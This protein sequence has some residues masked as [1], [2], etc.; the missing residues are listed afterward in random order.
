[1]IQ[2]GVLS[3]AAADFFE[4]SRSGSRVLHLPDDSVL[5]EQKNLLAHAKVFVCVRVCESVQY[6]LW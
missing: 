4:E 1:M 5:H 3:V 6:V 2:A